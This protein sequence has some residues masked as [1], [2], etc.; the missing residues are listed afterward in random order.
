MAWVSSLGPLGLAGLV[1]GLLAVV[2]LATDKYPQTFFRTWY[3]LPVFLYGLLYF[4]AA[5][6]LRIA[7]DG[8]IASKTLRLSGPA[9]SDP[10][11]QSLIVGLGASALWHIR[12]WNISMPGGA[13]PIGFETVIAPFERALTTWMDLD[14]FNSVRVYIQPRANRHPNLATVKATMMQNIPPSFND[15]TKA[16]VAASIATASTVVEAMEGYLKDCGRRSLERI[17]P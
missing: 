11:I 14:Q 13:F 10:W 15:T 5:V 12:V 7:F 3:T 8:L 9:I 2:Q 17:L 4:V 6:I 16:G 1:A